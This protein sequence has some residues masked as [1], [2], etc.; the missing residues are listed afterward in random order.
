MDKTPTLQTL[1]PSTSA[2]LS[3]TGCYK[4]AHELKF[5]PLR[6]AGP[7]VLYVIQPERLNGIPRTVPSHFVKALSFMREGDVKEWKLI[8]N[9]TYMYYFIILI[10]ELA[11]A[12]TLD[13]VFVGQVSS[14]KL[15]GYDLPI[16]YRDKPP[17]K[18]YLTSL[19]V[20]KLVAVV[21]NRGAGDATRNSLS[22][23]VSHWLDGI[24]EKSPEVRD[25]YH[26]L[27]WLYDILLIQPERK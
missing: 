11:T 22:V 19:A 7:N 5:D 8:G 13:S 15:D 12:Y 21:I 26:Q 20:T 9:A 24:Y 10:L 17:S 6:F 3:L 1:R 25:I 23:W 16:A 2:L 18:T 4:T 27:C 14:Y